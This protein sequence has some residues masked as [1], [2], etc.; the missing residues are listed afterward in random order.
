MRILSVRFKNLNSLTGQWHI[1]FTRPEYLSDGMFAITGPTGSGKTT[2]LDAVCLGLYGRTPRLD[3][4]TKSSNEIMSRQSGECFAEVTF[5]THKGRYRCHWSQHRARKRPEGELQQPRHEV[6]DAGTGAV[7]ESR[8]HQVAGFIEEATGMDFER[9][10][11]SMLLA[12]GDFAAFLLAS[13][14]ERA[15][16]LEQITGTGVYSLISMKVHERRA[17][18]RDRLER[19]IAELKGIQ[20]LSPEEEGDMRSSLEEKQ[21]YEKGLC[22][23]TEGLRRA[24]AW[25]ETITELEKGILELDK[26][27][28]DFERRQT[29]FE[30]E[31]IRLG[32]SH[33]ALGIEGDYRGVAALRDLQENETKDLH[34]VLMALPAKEKSCERA[35]ETKKTSEAGLEEARK[36]QRSE[37][38]II[39]K[40]REIDA[41]LGEQKKHID[42]KDKSILS[43]DKQCRAYSVNIDEAEQALKQARD[44]LKDVHDYQ[45]AHACDA[46]LL[47]DLAAISKVFASLRDLDGRRSKIRESL[48]AAA[49]ENESAIAAYRKIEADHEKTGEEFEKQQGE[50]KVLSRKAESILKGREISRWNQ[51]QSALKEREGFLK[52]THDIIERMTRTYS[53]LTEMETSL[54]QLKAG[55]ENLSRE[56]R[57]CTDKRALLVGSVAAME[58]QVSLLS[59]IRDLEEER[60]RLEDGKPCPLCGSND[61]PYAKG[62]I[63]ELNKAETQLQETRSE[64]KKVSDKLSKLEAEQATTFTEIRHVEKAMHENMAA[65]EGDEKQCSGNMLKLNIN[66]VP[67][68]R[69]GKVRDEIAGVQAKI[70]EISG[71]IVAAEEMNRKVKAAQDNL[72]KLR[73]LMEGSGRA[74]QEA[75]HNVDTARREHARL[76]KEALLLGED[77]EK[78]LGQALRDVEPFGVTQIPLTDLDSIFKGLTVRKV[79]WQTRLDEKNGLEKRIHDLEAGIGKDKALLEK[80]EN[81]LKDQRED[82]EDLMKQHASLRASRRGLYGEKNTDWEEKRFADAV[83][84]AGKAFEK[85]REEHAR[86]QQ[87]TSALKDKIDDLEKK[88]RK[89]ATELAQAE[90]N[91]TERIIKA[92][93]EGEADYLSAC[94]NEEEREGLAE[95]EK[96]LFREK[97][98]LDARRKDTFSALAT[99]KC[100]NLT[101]KSLETI[102]Q[103]ID[104]CDTGLSQIRIE[105]GGIMKTLSG[106]EKLYERQQERMKNIDAQKTE[107]VRWDNLHQLIG[108][109]DGKKFRNYAQGLTFEMMTAHANRQLQNMTDRYLLIRDE[110]QPLELNVIDNYQAGEIRSTRNLSGGESFIV[111]LALALGLSRMASRRVCV[112][113]LFLDEGFGTLDEDA[114]ETALETLAGLKQEGKLI[115]VISHVTALKERIGTQI[116]ITPETGGRSTLAGPGCSRI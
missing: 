108:S 91:L 9:F 28:E 16:I 88:T 33:R 34:C 43:L 69:S 102:R 98:Q 67:E 60:K 10:T 49:S 47:T 101:E 74:L 14:N 97:N 23:Q 75:K 90:Q 7:L 15:D 68:E 72:E 113:S 38:D 95:R 36:R 77:V 41:R 2:I 62:N 54:E 114:L 84:K 70:S 42:E 44:G 35:S 6:A 17:Y 18:E 1:D 31:K 4:V 46:G 80:L 3:K 32:R 12:Q 39:K 11:R 13:V 59:R 40:V 112:D 71:I 50:F 111:S 99:E 104:A 45:A 55:H 26:L 52:Q 20:I 73:A 86:M 21:L 51:E 107:C 106:N 53:V 94:L 63:P 61:H 56:I 27:K 58:T 24:A 87:E 64:L 92:G 30:P 81:D 29:V 83:D 100:K 89:R 22:G 48:K 93:F 19:L 105:I 115:G 78:A 82:R 116:Q 76:T 109:A 103:E 5:E 66:A 110:A 37:A 57:T 65:L 79:T 96:A 8:I 85:A 25:L